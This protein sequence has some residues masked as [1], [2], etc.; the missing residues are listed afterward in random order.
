MNSQSTLKTG[1]APESHTEPAAAAP[2]NTKTL[3]PQGS[4][5]R[6][7]VHDNTEYRLRITAQGKLILTK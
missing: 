7:I 2:L 3:F 5:E 6:T 4:R 1:T